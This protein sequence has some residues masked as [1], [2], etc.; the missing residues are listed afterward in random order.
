[1]CPLFL[2]LDWF[3]YS[4][5]PADPAFI[6]VNG[7]TSAVVDYGQFFNISFVFES[8]TG[9]ERQLLINGSVIA[10]AILVRDETNQQI[11]NFSVT[12]LVA[13]NG[14]YTLRRSAEQ[15]NIHPL[16]YITV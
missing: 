4:L 7:P 6:A 5:S 2:L 1:M 15:R 8:V 9:F 3:L 12:A 14:N 13:T 10:E 16:T 11:Y